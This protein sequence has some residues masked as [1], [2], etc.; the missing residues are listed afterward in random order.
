MSGRNQDEEE[1]TGCFSIDDLLQQAG[2]DQRRLSVTL[3]CLSGRCMG[4][5]FKLDAGPQV[6][7]RTEVA[8]IQIEDDGISR[9]HAEVVELD[10]SYIL[11]DLGST[12]GTMCKGAR[13]TGPAVLR[14]GDRIRLGPNAVLR[15]DYQD[16]LEEQMQSKLYDMATRDPLTGAYN[17]RFFVDRLG[18]E[19]AWAYR[20]R[21]ACAL[22]A[23]DIDHFK[24]VNDTWG[25]AAGDQVLKDVVAVVLRAIRKEDLFSRVGGEEFQLLAR[26]TNPGEA[27][28]LAE[29]VR[30]AVLKHVT[31]YGDQEIRITISLG[32]AT[33]AD[34]GITTPDQLVCRADELL[35]L[36]KQ[37]GRNRV[38]HNKLPEPPA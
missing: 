25:H 8:Q 4:R 11:R 1:R 14:D 26:A 23:I 29:R 6:I 16:E 12:N 32:V 2:R 3:T 21:R 27:V 9:K 33:S 20:H 24:A 7:G 5:V 30:A 10:G 15:F 22:V 34:E 13:L 37:N 19:W 35:Y 18:S 36:A 17:R 28:V 31:R 38:E